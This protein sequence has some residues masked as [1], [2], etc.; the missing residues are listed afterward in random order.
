[1]RDITAE[2]RAQDFQRALRQ[3]GQLLQ[4]MSNE[5]AERAIHES[6]TESRARLEGVS[7]GLDIAGDALV[8]ASE[9]DSPD[10][11][12]RLE[13]DDDDLSDEL[14]YAKYG[15]PRGAGADPYGRPDPQTHPEYWTE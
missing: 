13:V 8:S 12:T 7:E 14:F 15:E 2:M 1:M 11:P 5:Y 3:Y 9:W 10:H 6:D 4:G